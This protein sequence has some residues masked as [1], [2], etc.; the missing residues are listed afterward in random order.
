ML[1]KDDGLTLLVDAPSLFYR[2][3]F[4]TPETVTMPNGLPINAAHGFLRM[5]ARLIGDH[6]PG[7]IA[8]ASDE[9][10]RPE[11]RVELVESYKS[12]R[13][14]EGSQQEE[15]EEK[16]AHQVPVLYT[17]LEEC[18]IPV[19]GHP[20]AEAED[21][22]G[23]LTTRAPGP[24]AIFSGDRDLFQ[25]VEDPDVWILYPVR[26]VSQLDVVNESFI[27]TKYGIPGRAYFDYAVLRGD[28]SDGLP[29]VR[30]IGDKLA[31]SLVAK[32]GDLDAII[33]A[34]E[35]GA[36]G[37]VIEKVRKDLDYVKRARQVVAITRDLDIPEVDL[38]RP[39]QLPEEDLREMSKA[40]GLENSVRALYATL[41][42][43]PT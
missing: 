42:G 1:Q 33:A 25:L 23:T 18:G 32:Y 6:Q 40:Y 30:G 4:S 39:E 13:A 27:A 19:I 3:L 5:L 35:D 15:A 28:P 14:E 20:D 26:G 22:I 31:R 36:V 34:V 8:C 2:A 41:T 29:G 9:N 38:M 17:L 7:Y 16:L 12:H 24:V 37:S 10:W 21:V 43:T 11:W